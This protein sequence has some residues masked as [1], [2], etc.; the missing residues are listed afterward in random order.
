MLISQRISTKKNVPTNYD[1]VELKTFF[2]N[3]E[4]LINQ[5]KHKEKTNRPIFKHDASEKIVILDF[6]KLNENEIAVIYD[7]AKNAFGKSVVWAAVS[8]SN[9]GL[10]I[11]VAVNN[12]AEKKELDFFKM[13][14]PTL[15]KN[16]FGFQ[17]NC[18]CPNLLIDLN[19]NFERFR[20]PKIKNEK[21]GLKFSFTTKKSKYTLPEVAKKFPQNSERA[22]S[23]F[24]KFACAA[25]RDAHDFDEIARAGLDFY[26]GLTFSEI[27]RQCKNAQKFIENAPLKASKI[28]VDDQTDFS[29][30]INALLNKFVFSGSTQKIAIQAQTGLGKTYNMHVFSQNKPTIL[31]CPT[32]SLTQQTA[33]TYN[34]GALCGL[35]NDQ[36]LIERFAF[37]NG[38][39]N[40]IAT[41][42]DQIKQFSKTLLGKCIVVVDEA[43][44]LVNSANYRATTINAFVNQ[45][46]FAEKLIY[47][48]ATLPH[49]Y[50]KLINV[51]DIFRFE[52]KTVEKRTVK[53]FLYQN[54]VSPLLESIKKDAKEN[55]FYALI[56]LNNKEII[57]GCEDSE[58]CGIY[59]FEG[60]EKSSH[61]IELIENSTL[62]QRVT[63]VTSKINAGIN[64]KM[65]NDNVR[66]Y[67]IADRANLNGISDSDV[68]QFFGRFRQSKSIQFSIYERSKKSENVIFDYSKKSKIEF[69]EH[70]KTQ[71]DYLNQIEKIHGNSSA[72]AEKQINGFGLDLCAIQNYSKIWEMDFCK[73]ALAF[74]K[75]RAKASSIVKTLPKIDS[76]YVVE[77]SDVIL[78]FG[79]P[80]EKQQG[81]EVQIEF[82]NSV[83]ENVLADDDKCAF[84]AHKSKNKLLRKYFKRKSIN[85]YDIPNAAKTTFVLTAF[86]ELQDIGF[87]K[88]TAIENLRGKSFGEVETFVNQSINYFFFVTEKKKFNL[89]QRQDKAILHKLCEKFTEFL[90]QNLTEKQIIKN[91]KKLFCRPKSGQI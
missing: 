6:D 91:S 76:R 3:F 22:N 59:N 24:Y 21:Q 37:E 90:G 65:T 77:T 67:Y 74:E 15:D 79:V 88:R 60:L 61:Y 73:I 48:S 51:T 66:A 8:P 13:L 31:C 49:E 58:T 86:C 52:A 81:K 62:K 41:T 69:L 84:V 78:D 35:S 19:P 33:Q 46:E 82:V 71:I 64:I 28:L 53:H 39:I 26:S 56:F 89:K 40:F 1:V 38:A 68:C 50:L 16:A 11:A 32:I 80:A 87:S 5:N 72:F 44:E 23:S 2:S 17:T 34:C 43:H 29:L 27:E 18:F 30:K 63:V 10:K 47:L 70:Q 54:D 25:F 14:F 9:K 57:S 83:C 7:R 36:D 75:R 85:S 55:N 12:D 4:L 45:I 20:L 42:Y